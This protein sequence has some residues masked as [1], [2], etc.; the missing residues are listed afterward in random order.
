MPGM[1]SYLCEI[2]AR[3]SFLSSLRDPE[4]NIRARKKPLYSLLKCP[5]IRIILK[6]TA[7][8]AHS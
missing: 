2:N 5:K 6:T 3:Y 7:L 4:S 1:P 8:P